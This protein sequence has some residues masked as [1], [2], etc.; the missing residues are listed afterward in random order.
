MKPFKTRSG[1]LK[2]LIE[3]LKQRIKEFPDLYQQRLRCFL[4]DFEKTKAA[5]CVDFIKKIN[6]QGDI[7]IVAGGLPIYLFA[8]LEQ[9]TKTNFTQLN[10]IKNENGKVVSRPRERTIKEITD[11]NLIKRNL[12]KYTILNSDDQ[13]LLEIVL[14]PVLESTKIKIIDYSPVVPRFL[15][16]IREFFP[17]LNFEYYNR[18]VCFDNIKEITKDTLVIIPN[19]EYLY[20]LNE[21]DILNE[22]DYF[23]IFNQKE[24][25][26]KRKINEVLCMDDLLDQITAKEIITQTRIATLDFYSYFVAGQV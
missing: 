23:I 24:D 12:P 5:Y 3:D 4:Y 13:E 22:N 14:D 10:F 25:N 8:F 19:S 17:E 15:P 1:D 26:E 2:T 11:G 21:L 6:W 9:N 20:I 7:S 16:L 18:N